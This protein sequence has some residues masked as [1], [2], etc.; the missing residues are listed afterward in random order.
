MPAMTGGANIETSADIASLMGWW[1]DAGLDVLVDEEPRDWLAQVERVAPAP[2]AP[3]RAAAPQA[4]PAPAAPTFPD[5]LPAFRE[6]LATS[7]QLNIP[8]GARIAASGDP[9]SGLMVLVDLPEA[10]DMAAG[11]LLSGP[12]GELFDK[13]IA[14]IGRNR[15]SLYLAAMAPGRPAG[16]YVDKASGTLFGELARHHV[17]LAK[18]RALLL[19]GDP[20]ARAFLSQGFV[21]AR[22]RQHDVALPGG[23]TPAIATFH[24]RTLLHHPDQK[25]RAWEDLQLLMKILG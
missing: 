4:A 23:A 24:P 19:M 7:D 10:D 14:A 8:L 13:M 5:S 11:T 22:G 21:E 1:R 25:R 20:P 16:G 2:V 3:V 6:W 9:A 15:E 12:A 18:P 17:T